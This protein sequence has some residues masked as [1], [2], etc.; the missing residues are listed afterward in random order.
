[1][2]ALIRSG[3]AVIE[4]KN[5]A[6]YVSV[7]PFI[8]IFFVILRRICASLLDGGWWVGEGKR[9]PAC[10]KIALVDMKSDL[11]DNKDL[12]IHKSTKKSC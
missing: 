8:H 2:R 4:A 1:M 9:R 3:E 10:I 11:L 5:V 12:N 6:S 7:K